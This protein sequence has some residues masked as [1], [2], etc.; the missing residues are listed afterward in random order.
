MYGKPVNGI[1]KVQSPRLLG[2]QM[3]NPIFVSAV[4]RRLGLPNPDFVE[5]M[6]CLKCGKDLDPHD[7]HALVCADL[8]GRTALQS[9]WIVW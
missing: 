8:K 7:S 5:G 4:A 2:A 3:S 1:P 9:L 6:E